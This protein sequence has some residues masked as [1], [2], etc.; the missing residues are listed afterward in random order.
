MHFLRLVEAGTD[1]LKACRCL[2]SWRCLGTALPPGLRALVA[3][4]DMPMSHAYTGLP[5]HFACRASCYAD[6]A[7]VTGIPAWDGQR[8]LQVTART[9]LWKRV[10]AEL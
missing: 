9:D 4:V 7:G 2:L 3:S 10:A 1:C 5:S 8:C 6:Y